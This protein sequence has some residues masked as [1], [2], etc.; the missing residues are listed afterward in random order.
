MSFSHDEGCFRTDI[1]CNREETVNLF[2]TLKNQ[3]FNY[4]AIEV[5]VVV[6]SISVSS[7]NPTYLNFTDVCLELEIIFKTLLIL[8]WK[9]K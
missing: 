6:G 5:V 3:H 2:V 7:S 8:L 9:V 4:K 1:E